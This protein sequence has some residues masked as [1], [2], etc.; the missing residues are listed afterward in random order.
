[1]NMDDMSKFWRFWW[2]WFF[3]FFNRSKIYSGEMGYTW[4]CSLDLF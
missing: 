4:I 1:M 2:F 3:F